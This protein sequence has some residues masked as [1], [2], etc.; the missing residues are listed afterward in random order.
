M[1]AEKLNTTNIP[2]SEVERLAAASRLHLQGRG[3]EA[4]TLYRDVLAT[5]P[6]H[7]RALVLLATLLAD[8]GSVDEAEAMLR[9]RLGLTDG[10]PI[11]PET[12][13]PALAA[14][15]APEPD[16]A[17]SRLELAMVLFELGNLRQ[18]KRDDRASLLLFETATGLKPDYSVA[19]NN[20]ALSLHRLG[21]RDL[22]LDV[23][24]RALAI[25][26]KF[27]VALRN[28]GQM[29]LEA[30]QPEA[31][32]AAFEHWTA[33]E[34]RSVEALTKLGIAALAVPDVAR[35]EVALRRALALD[36]NH[37]EAYVQLAN[38]LDHGHRHGEALG[39]RREAARR[40]GVVSQA[41]LSGRS[42]ARVLVVGGAG[43]C[44][45]N[46]QCLLDRNRFDATIVYLQPEGEEDA[47][48]A[49][50]PGAFPPCDIVINSIADVDNGGEF[51]E[52]ARAFCARFDR[53]VVN[54]PDHRIART[55]RDGVAGLLEGIRGLTVPSTRRLSW[56]EV[57]AMA[58]KPLA[59]PILLRPVGAHGGDDLERIDDA[60]Q[61]HSFLS[62]VPAE[63]FYLTAFH[64]YRSA[65][66]YWRKYR[67]VFVDRSVFPYHLTIGRD[68]KLHYYRVD[69]TEQAWM[70]PKE[71]AFLADWRSV[72]DGPRGEAIA[73]V[74]RRIDLDFAGIDCAIGPDGNVVLFEANPTMLVHLSESPIEY[75]YK[76]RYVPRIFDAFGA[77]LVRRAAEDRNRAA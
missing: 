36:P 10:D 50:P 31:A 14:V 59:G 48:F 70:K 64:D 22:A 29:L 9:R 3:A 1:N 53:P 58:E 25:D 16:I 63:S 71:E 68:W 18:R 73:E 49:R 21:R 44:N 42:D 24:Q 46:L 39:Y 77:M 47:V 12:L 17:A 43:L 35:A 30:R 60:G 32:C 72:F 34:P 7:P 51:L 13:A 41:S 20:M 15:A 67:L 28:L 26:P 75:P 5:A 4:M 27:I 2:G 8:T 62:R 45:L 74:A 57:A 52:K 11:V 66:G 65:D 19:F 56:A 76:H 61:I 38:A 54:A 37:V 33:I 55:T 6:D 40:H 69:M 23:I